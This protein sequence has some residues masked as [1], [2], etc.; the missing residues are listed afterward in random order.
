MNDV[1]SEVFGELDEYLRGLFPDINT[2]GEE[3]RSPAKFPFVSIVEADNTTRTDTS[4]SGNIENHV[5]VMFEINVYTNKSSGKKAQ[6]KEI[7]SAIDTWFIRHGFVRTMK[8]P[9]NMD[10]ATK[11]RIVG[12]YSGSV[13]KDMKVYRR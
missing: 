8:N 11:Y 7:F 9:V 1:E 12:R 2:S 10:D 5:N 13:S 4:D 6:A 3:N